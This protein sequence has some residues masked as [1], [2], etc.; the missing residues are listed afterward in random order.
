MGK[1]G[2]KN[3]FGKIENKVFCINSFRYL[4]IYVDFLGIVLFLSFVRILVFWI[5]GFIVL[6]D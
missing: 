2:E 6:G 3:G 4:Y 5:F 1:W